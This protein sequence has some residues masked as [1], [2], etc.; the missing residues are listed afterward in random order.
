MPLDIF[1]KNV[2]PNLEKMV[3]DKHLVKI[4]HAGKGLTHISPL[5]LRKILFPHI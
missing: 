1:E 2:L 4:K 5:L 3:T